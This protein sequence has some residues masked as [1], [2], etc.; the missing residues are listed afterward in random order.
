MVLRDVSSCIVILLDMR[1]N[2][3]KIEHDHKPLTSEF[4]SKLHLK[5]GKSR[6]TVHWTERRPN[7]N[8]IPVFHPPVWLTR[9]AAPKT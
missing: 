1:N 9:P 4:L 6:L 2:H 8:A 3:S 7:K 5:Y